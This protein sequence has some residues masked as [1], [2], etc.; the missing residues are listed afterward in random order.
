MKL[1][2]FLLALPILFQCSTSNNKVLFDYAY[3]DPRWGIK[4]P[5]IFE[6]ALV[7]RVR[8]E[9]STKYFWIQH[10]KKDTS[11]KD[12]YRFDVYLLTG[13]YLG[14]YYFRLADSIQYPTR[15]IFEKAI[16]SNTYSPTER[17]DLSEYFLVQNESYDLFLQTNDKSYLMYEVVPSSVK[18]KDRNRLYYYDY[19]I[20][21]NVEAHAA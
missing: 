8:L 13:T 21:D 9:K 15:N 12:C 11:I 3:P 10:S 19:T 5:V 7:Q 18:G 2:G 6:N 14:G 1:W 17:I 4:P 20:P 16:K